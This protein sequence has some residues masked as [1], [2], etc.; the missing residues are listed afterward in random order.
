[1]K[2]YEAVM[3]VTTAEAAR[4][5]DS[6][7]HHITDI[8]TRNGAEVVDLRK[9][10]ERK[11]AYEIKHQRK[12]TYILIHFQAPTNA[13][14]QMRQELQLSERILRHLITVDEDGVEVR[15]LSE[16][17][18]ELERA[19]SRRGKEGRATGTKSDE[20]KPADKEA[21]ESQEAGQTAEASTVTS[22]PQEEGSPEE[23]EAG[24]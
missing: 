18:E 24:L 15:L 19:A 7:V 16:V 20:A 10:G 14:A 4:D 12:A 17:E 21:D 2:L 3:L 1:M 22:R 11:L 8:L 5:W 13:I 23:Q 9:W 6:L